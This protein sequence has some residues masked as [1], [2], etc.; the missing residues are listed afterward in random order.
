MRR[1]RTPSRPFKRW[2][3]IGTILCITVAPAVTA[4]AMAQTEEPNCQFVPATSV[5]TGANDYLAPDDGDG[6]YQAYSG[7]DLLFGGP[8]NDIMCGAGGND[9][10]HVGLG[11]DVIFPGF[12]VDEIYCGRG[13][14]NVYEHGYANYEDVNYVRCESVVVLPY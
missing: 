6:V 14:D 12:G 9:E 3:L 7:D 2:A 13:Y 10:I 4:S 8:G 5:G 11:D 1:E